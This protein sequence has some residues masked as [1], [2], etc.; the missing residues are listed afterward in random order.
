M[1]TLQ[2]EQKV[3]TSEQKMLFEMLRFNSILLNLGKLGYKF[4]Q[5]DFVRNLKS[6]TT[7]EYETLILRPMI[8]YVKKMN[9]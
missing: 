2:N 8:D 7:E 1:L 9:I 3:E 4:F 6:I 5:D